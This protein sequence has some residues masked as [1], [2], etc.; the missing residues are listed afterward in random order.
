MNPQPNWMGKRISRLFFYN[1][2]F[3]IKYS[4]KSN[5]P[6]KQRNQ[7]KRKFSSWNEQNQI[8]YSLTVFLLSLFFC[9]STR[10]KP[11]NWPSGK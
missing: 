4:I 1:G 6:L 9:E 5:M 3:H 7:T 8:C 11:T 2:D 10:P